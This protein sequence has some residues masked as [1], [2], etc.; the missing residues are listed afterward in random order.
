[1][2]KPDPVVTYR[3][4]SRSR[5]LTGGEKK[6]T[7]KK[8]HISWPDPF[9]LRTWKVPKAELPSVDSGIVVNKVE[10]VIQDA[11]V[12]RP[13]R[14]LVVK[15]SEMIKAMMHLPDIPHPQMDE[16]V[17]EWIVK[18]YTVEHFDPT[19]RAYR[20][21]RNQIVI[22]SFSGDSAGYGYDHTVDKFPRLTR[23]VCPVYRHWRSVVGDKSPT[24][25]LFM[26]MPRASTVLKAYLKTEIVNNKIRTRADARRVID[27]LYACQLQ[28]LLW[29]AAAQ[30]SDLQYS[31]FD[32]HLEN[33]LVWTSK[34]PFYIKHAPSYVR[35]TVKNGD[36]EQVI[37]VPVKARGFPWL[38]VFDF[39][40][41][42]SDRWNDFEFNNSWN[43]TVVGFE[44]EEK[45]HRMLR[46]VDV[47]RFLTEVRVE[48]AGLIR[49]LH[50]NARDL[51]DRDALTEWDRLLF[52]M[53]RGF[54]LTFH[55]DFALVRMVQSEWGLFRIPV[56]AF[57]PEAEWGGEPSEAQLR[58]DPL[59]FT[60]T[61]NSSKY[62]DRR[63]QD[64]LKSITAFTALTTIMTSS[65]VK[66]MQEIRK[67]GDVDTLDVIQLRPDV[68][69]P[70]RQKIH[71]S[72][73]TF[74]SPDDKHAIPWPRD[75][76]ERVFEVTDTR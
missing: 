74:V 59:R 63:M 23:F 20:A 41:S 48:V 72:N 57:R 30:S 50:Q 70:I 43:K 2:N 16:D 62:P 27:K 19:S 11:E 58:D 76:R 60:I 51:F 65:R 37:T 13:Y 71:G 28:V 61:A 21:I 40:Q 45:E 22:A 7:V 14:V 12:K 36:E 69:R 29:I 54:G 18:D 47:V 46:Y 66:M 4:S 6:E 32:L 1:M 75:V 25:H 52:A 67:R 38:W 55:Q 15:H 73:N 64:K 9:Q 26:A 49:R 44:Y 5:A 8:H 17:D 68:E 3:Y 35:V 24:M 31:H 56:S 39:D 42:R 34:S 33:V 10:T 53:T